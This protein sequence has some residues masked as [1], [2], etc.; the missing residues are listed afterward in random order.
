MKKVIFCV[1]LI[2]F[3][4][5][6]IAVNDATDAEYLFIFDA[7]DGNDDVAND[8][9]ANAVLQDNSGATIQT[10]DC[11]GNYTYCSLTDGSN[12]RWQLNESGVA[13]ADGLNITMVLFF[14]PTRN[15][16]SGDFFAGD[17][18][19]FFIQSKGTNLINFTYSQSGSYPT[20]SM[21]EYALNTTYYVT[22]LEMKQNS[23]GWFWCAYGSHDDTPDCKSGNGNYYLE[24]AVSVGDRDTAGKATRVYWQIFGIY[25]R[26]LNS[27]ERAMIDEKFR[28][29]IT[30]A[31]DLTDSGA[32][33]DEARY[34][35][36]TGKNNASVAFTWYADSNTQHTEVWRD[37]T[38]I[39]NS[40]DSSVNLTG[41]INN[42]C[43][44]FNFVA[45]NSEGTQANNKTVW[46]C[47]LNNGVSLY[48]DT[49]NIRYVPFLLT[50]RW[51][52]DNNLLGGEG[53]QQVF[54]IDI[55]PFNSS[56]IY[57][58][59]D[60]TKCWRS[61]NAGQNWRMLAVNVSQEGASSIVSDPNNANIVL[62]MFGR[63][64]GND[65][66]KS[67]TEGLYRS[68]DGGNNW[69]AE[70]SSLYPRRQKNGQ[71]IFYLN[72]TYDT[73]LNC[74]KRIYA[75]AG[76]GLYNSSDCGATW[77]HVAGMTE[78]VN[79]ISGNDT[80]AYVATNESLYLIDFSDNSLTS[81]SATGMGLGSTLRD[82]AVN[83]SNFNNLICA[84]TDVWES[85][86]GGDSFT[87]ILN[88]SPSIQN[89][90]FGSSVMFA[91]PSGAG[92]SYPYRSVNGGA[93]WTQPTLN[94]SI[95][96]HNDFSWYFSEPVACAADES[97]CFTSMDGALSKS[98]DLGAT[99]NESSSG[100]T[101]ARG[102]D[103]HFI[104][105]THAYMA[106]W[107]YGLY[108]VD[109]TTGRATDLAITGSGSDRS[110]GCVAVNGSTIITTYGKWGG[111]PYMDLIRSTD[112]GSSWSTV[113]D[114]TVDFYF[115]AFSSDNPNYV[116]ADEYYSD[117]GGASWQ[118]NGASVIAS[119]MVGGV[120]YGLKDNGATIGIYNSTD[121]NSWN[122]IVSITTGES[123]QYGGVKVDPFDTDHFLLGL[124]DGG[125][126]ECNGGSCSVRAAGNGL[127]AT[128]NYKWVHFDPNRQGYAW[129]GKIPFLVSGFPAEF[130]LSTDGGTNWA[131]ASNN[132]GSGHPL[133]AINT[134]PY[135]TD[136]L[137]FT[138]SG[139]WL[140]G[141]TEYTTGY[142]SVLDWYGQTA[143]TP[144]AAA[145][146]TPTPT[147]DLLNLSQNNESVY[148]N[149][150][151]LCSA[152]CL[153][154]VNGVNVI[155]ISSFPYNRTGLTNATSY[156]FNF[157]V[158]NSN[159][160]TAESNFSNTITVTTLQNTATPAAPANTSITD[161]ETDYFNVQYITSGT[162]AITSILGFIGIF[163][164]V[165]ILGMFITNVQQPTNYGDKKLDIFNNV[166]LLIIGVLFLL[167]VMF[168]IGMAATV[169]F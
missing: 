143:P 159:Y 29:G 119:D 98:T 106:A 8:G 68:T 32:A 31:S 67:T 19:A 127:P 3:S 120:F 62:A 157:T 126:G 84:K 88:P 87:R 14:K 46:Q 43:Y 114:G 70:I 22:F 48:A 86:D 12:D 146:Q 83:A 30:S 161:V 53:W 169:I 47:T 145:N 130:Y 17:N 13:I 27:T 65:P 9:S 51:Q 113:Y 95:A 123:V 5:Y 39:E 122:L 58:C 21:L 154:Y 81:L 141:F 80:H 138:G 24:G 20:V 104:N 89:V 129:T 132:A 76:S 128:S 144:P 60:T 63:M 69:V 100:M 155:N 153:L 77:S 38:F 42:T 94:T 18:D 7:I 109:L 72:N 28:E 74:T 140:A 82:C 35:R 168:L 55:N 49:T 105:Q 73:T 56:I 125:V 133:Y 137:Y 26:T 152:K 121:G 25:H 45:T 117:D 156:S 16:D 6:V 33:P 75:G 50:S 66:Q 57:L 149:A 151:S 108:Y 102:M 166:I 54:S 59:T 4:S 52:L 40:T 158:Y 78:Y 99:W 44:T 2:L 101:G 142:A 36:M 79:D 90:Y 110:A 118:A 136:Q 93:T 92:G 103:F 162:N 131:A 61:I 164:I 124:A 41:L 134:N 96:V 64:T 1:F 165:F 147:A 163:I 150:S 135:T 148:L 15:E 97:Y 71:Q 160:T 139:I 10:Q 34:I 167:F 91:S 37:N 85:E 107:D 115:C 112:G 11:A 111:S 23:S 116:V